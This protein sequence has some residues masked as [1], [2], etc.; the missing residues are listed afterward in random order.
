MKDAIV[1]YLSDGLVLALV[2]FAVPAAVGSMFTGPSFAHIYSKLPSA[3][4]PMATAVMM[5]LF[6]LIGLGL[7]PVMVGF[8]S[9]MLAAHHGE[10]SLRYA[11]VVLQLSGLWAAVH[12]WLAGNAVKLEKS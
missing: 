7:G 8:I 3:Q 10:N 9:D 6:N 2:V 11:L 1:F 4:R 5:F 12:F